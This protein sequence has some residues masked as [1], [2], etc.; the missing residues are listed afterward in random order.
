M[1]MLINGRLVGDEKIEIHNPYNNE[2]IDKVPAASKEDTREAISAAKT[3]K[4]EMTLL[5]AL[6]ISDALYDA[7][8][9]LKKRLDEFSRLITLDS[10]KPI[11]AALDEVKR[12]IETL[13]LSAEES[14]RIYGESIPMDAGIGG[15]NFIGFTIKIP[16]GVI[17]AITPFNFPINLAIHKIGPALAS[18][19]TVILKPSLKAPLSP[20][21][22]GELLNEYFPPGAINVLTGK[23]SIIGEEILKSED[24]DK[25]TFTGG[26]K[27]G[28]MIAEKSG[29]KKLTL[30]LGG[31]DPII[32]LKDA[33]IE[34]A[35][36]GAL[37]GS[38][39]YSG[40]VCIAVKRI[41]VD[42]KIADEFVQRLVKE[43]S[44][45]KIGDPLNPKT[46]IGPLISEK[47][48]LEIEE[49][50]LEAINDGAELLYGGRRNG[51]FFEPTVL[52]NVKPSMRLVQEE[53][54]G[55]VSPIIRVKDAEEALKVA[56]DTCYALQAGVFTEN[57]H[58]ALRFVSKLRAGTVLINKQPTY[59]VDHMPF[60]GFGCSGMGKE[61]VRY[62]IE[63]M[64]RTKLIIFNKN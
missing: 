57:I 17:A 52:D 54:F 22:L 27:T 32:V 44:K 51:N 20:L 5:T 23:A 4:D 45:L 40:Q 2:V 33:N 31:N 49:V 16:L 38:Y 34:K 24:I 55:P 62:A 1:K 10:G 53:T 63:D 60:G 6:K 21:K 15:K 39:L 18:K 19:N 47:A 35:V 12:S 36:E 3:A 59:R 11:K 58:E 50:V 26:F 41:I 46:D 14:K 25:I 48:A 28:K 42:E 56:N 9:E 8:Q 29:M 13:K 43:T 37:K 64:T 61:G 7:S 30:E